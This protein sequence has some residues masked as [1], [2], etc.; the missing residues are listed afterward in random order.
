ML[1][2]E[3]E[4][5]VTAQRPYLS[6]HVKSLNMPQTVFDVKLHHVSIGSRL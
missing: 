5:T 3:V 2:L 6:L 1:F 4:L